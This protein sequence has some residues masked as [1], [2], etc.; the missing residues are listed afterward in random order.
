LAELG[1]GVAPWKSALEAL[2]D[3]LSA[4]ERARVFG[5]NAAD[6]YSLS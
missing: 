1:G 4:S 2:L 6:A 5:G 3:G